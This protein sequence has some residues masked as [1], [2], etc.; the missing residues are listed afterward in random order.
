[1]NENRT[2]HKQLSIF[3]LLNYNHLERPN[4][5]AMRIMYEYNGID[6]QKT[7]KVLNKDISPETVDDIIAWLEKNVSTEHLI[8]NLDSN[9]IDFDNKFNSYSYLA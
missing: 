3:D 6:G 9:G 5:K 7:F 2:V 1:M 4:K 8:Y